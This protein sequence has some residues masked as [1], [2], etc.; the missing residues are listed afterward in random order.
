MPPELDALTQLGV[1]YSAQTDG[2]WEHQHGVTIET[3]DNP[4]WSL[5]VEL[6]GTGISTRELARVER[7]GDDA[8]WLVVWRDDDAFHAACGPLNLTEAV[9]TFLAWAAG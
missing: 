8:D 1:W 6:C 2:D 3:I 9:T 5:R 4:G 7:H